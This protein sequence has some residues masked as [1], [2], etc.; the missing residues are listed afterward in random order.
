MFTKTLK[1]RLGAAVAAVSLLVTAQIA[2][3]QDTAQTTEPPAPQ[4]VYVF[5]NSLV[6]HLTDT[7]LFYPSC[8]CRRGT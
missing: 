3:A 4:T 6:H 8:R 1:Q 5:G 2:T 7:C